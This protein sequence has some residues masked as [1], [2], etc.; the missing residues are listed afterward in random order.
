MKLY[1]NCDGDVCL[2]IEGRGRQDT[3]EYWVK[4][5]DARLKKNIRTIEDPLDRILRLRGVTF[6][7]QDEKK[8]RFNSGTQLGFIS[9][10][11][12]QVFPQW[13]SDDAEG[14]KLLATTG[15]DALAVEA[16]RELDR[17]ISALESENKE[18]KARIRSLERK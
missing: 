7:W 14:Y 18:L 6:E 5:S 1:N 11:V 2:D 16:L 15:F 17:K 9:Q 4:N 13:V 12:E 3:S 8:T 10:E